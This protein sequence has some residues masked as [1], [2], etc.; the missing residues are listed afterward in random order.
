MWSQ[1]G[2]A[3]TVV[4]RAILPI[5]TGDANADQT[6]DTGVRLLDEGKLNQRTG[7]IEANARGQI[8]AVM[9]TTN[10]KI[11]RT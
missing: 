7:K 9:R 2:G 4:Q 10:F 1:Q 5:K 3:D 11:S 6:I 8:L